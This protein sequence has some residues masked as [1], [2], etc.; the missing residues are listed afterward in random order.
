MSSQTSASELISR[1][2]LKPHPE[3]GWYAETFR[4]NVTVTTPS[5]TGTRCASTA[6]YFLVAPGSVSRLHRIQSDECW[7]FYM[8]H[9]LTIVEIDEDSKQ[10]ILTQLGNDINRGEIPQYVVKAN[11]WFGS[12]PSSDD[13]DSFSFV[14]CTVAPGFEFSD[15]EL[16]SRA[17]LLE[18]FPLASEMIVKLTEGLP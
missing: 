12:F 8:G 2:G 3:G 16:A 10:C 17:D 13:P 6:I 4:S 15:F 1:F 11:R 14:G 9:P 5:T 7:H 18:K